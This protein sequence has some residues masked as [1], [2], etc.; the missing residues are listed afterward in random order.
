MKHIARTGLTVLACPAQEEDCIVDI[1]FVHGLQGHPKRTW[2]TQS[3]GPG[4]ESL[5]S[6]G[7]HSSW[8][9]FF[10]RKRKISESQSDNPSDI[11]WPQDLLPQDCSSARILTFGYDSDVSKFFD[12]A[13]NSNNFYDHANDLLRA[14]LRERL[15]AARSRPIIFVAH[16]LGGIIV[17][18]ALV[19]SQRAERRVEEKSIHHYT[20]AVIFLGTP[21]RGSQYSSWGQIA[22]RI[23]RAAFFDTNSRNIS[24][25]Q[26]HGT[27]LANLERDFLILLDRQTFSVFNFQEALGFKGIKGLNGKIVENWSSSI[28]DHGSEPSESINANHMNMCRFYGKHDPGYKQVGGEILIKVNELVRKH[29]QE[30]S[31][32]HADFLKSLLGCIP[33]ESFMGYDIKDP[34]DNTCGWLLHHHAFSDWLQNGNGIFWMKGNPGAGKSIL[35]KYLLTDHDGLLHNRISSSNHVVKAGFFFRKTRSS[36]ERTASSMFRAILAQLF[37]R[38]KE[39]YQKS[40]SALRSL[41]GPHRTAEHIKWSDQ[42]LHSVFERICQGL[43]RDVPLRFLIFLDALDESLDHEMELVLSCLH[44]LLSTA[45][46]HNIILGI[47]ISSRPLPALDRGADVASGCISLQRENHDAIYTY[48]RSELA[49]RRDIR[50]GEDYYGRFAEKVV[51]RADGVFLWVALVVPRLRKRIDNGGTIRELEALLQDIPNDLK[52]LFVDILQRI[53]GPELEITMRMLQLATLVQRRLTLEEFQHALAFQPGTP[54][55]S[56]EDWKVSPDFLELGQMVISRL[57]YY[58]GGLLEVQ[59]ELEVEHDPVAQYQEFLQ[60]GSTRPLSPDLERTRLP[61]AESLTY[62]ENPQDALRDTFSMGKP[63]KQLSLRSDANL[64]VPR[65][66][67]QTKKDTLCGHIRGTEWTQTPRSTSPFQDVWYIPPPRRPSSPHYRVPVVRFIHETAKHFFYEYD[68][69]QILYDLIRDS[70]SIKNAHNIFCSPTGCYLTGGHEFIA[71]SCVSYLNL[72]EL[73]Q[74]V[75]KV[76]TPSTT[77]QIIEFPF[78][79]YVSESWLHHLHAAEEGG[80]AQTHILEWLLSVRPSALNHFVCWAGENDLKSWIRWCIEN[81]ADV[82]DLDA[83][84]VSYGQPIRSAVEN[85]FY[86]IAELLIQAGANVNGTTGGPETTLRA[87]E[88]RGNR[89]MIKMLRKNRGVLQQPYWIPPEGQVVML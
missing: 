6:D 60:R 74:N 31:E 79:R 75:T 50:R 48:I 20:D 76:L 24:S 71:N 35:M 39:A 87:A 26:V 25:L 29:Q 12:G 46:K 54:Y 32:E 44:R 40:L 17:K 36:S 51:E 33:E 56:L 9:D 80:V 62:R 67:P 53:P 58:S 43:R 42:Q 88:R 4:T 7:V 5:E 34:H 1:I 19:D 89:R 16:S 27:E 28:G 83:T 47:C 65:S 59:G 52:E 81:E 68:G 64:K 21:H 78:A 86:E 18:Q 72:K 41:K 2:S 69:F 57:Q 37:Q 73:K 38:E 55:K 61:M 11:F 8:K 77:V 23:A 85:G 70:G 63:C 45:R 22:E 84:L 82:N 13:V 49:S 10:H 3:R 30:L 66:T 15:G 14:L